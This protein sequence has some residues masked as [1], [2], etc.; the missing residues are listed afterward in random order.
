ME[1]IAQRLVA[2]SAKS[3]EVRIYSRAGLMP[4]SVQAAQI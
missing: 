3:R 4:I 1:F 2:L